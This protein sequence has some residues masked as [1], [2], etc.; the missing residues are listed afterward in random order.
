ML[1]IIIN[2]RHCLSV[3]GEYGF[4]ERSCPVLFSYYFDKKERKTIEVAWHDMDGSRAGWQSAWW[5]GSVGPQH[6][7]ST[8]IHLLNHHCS[9]QFIQTQIHVRTRTIEWAWVCERT[10]DFRTKRREEKYSRQIFTQIHQHNYQRHFIL[11]QR[12]I[13]KRRCLGKFLR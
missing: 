13:T 5:I 4:R 10:T 1:C 3:W 6:H 7:I 2:V 8:H 9:I 12:N 11:S